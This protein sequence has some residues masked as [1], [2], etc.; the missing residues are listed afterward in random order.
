MY[1]LC[2]F[3]LS[4]TGSVCSKC[5]KV[6]TVLKICLYCKSVSYCTKECRMKDW[7]HKMICSLAFLKAEYCLSKSNND[8]EDVPTKT[9]DGNHSSTMKVNDDGSYLESEIEDGTGN[10]S[11]STQSKCQTKK[12][13]NG[14]ST[15]DKIEDCFSVGSNGEGGFVVY[16]RESENDSEEDSA[17]KPKAEY[18]IS[19]SNNYD[20]G[21]SA[22]VKDEDRFF[23]MEANDHAVSYFE[24]AFE[25]SAEAYKSS[26]QS[27]FQANH[28]AKKK[29]EVDSSLKAENPSQP[30]FQDIKTNNQNDAIAGNS[31]EVCMCCG[32]EDSNMKRCTKCKSVA[33]CSHECQRTDWKRHRLACQTQ[34][35]PTTVPLMSCCN[36]CG[37]LGTE[38]KKCGQCKN[39][40][41]CGPECQRTDWKN[42][43][44][45][46]PRP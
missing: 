27:K 1:I 16:R 14:P 15:K 36:S 40:S 23:T 37:V 42:H 11:A 10:D 3:E 29:N 28:S 12:T 5:K 39:A 32:L 35:L 22:K 41:Y 44:P 17:L 9:Q 45:T 21:A 33:Y 19:N 13:D 24:S 25:D 43:K 4:V 20:G 34:Q 30:S 7:L 38:M 6:T 8:D 46:C 31:G 26:M 18:C 2:M